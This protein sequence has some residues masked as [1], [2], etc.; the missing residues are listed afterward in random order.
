VMM[1]C[2]G[3]NDSRC[4][5]VDE[6]SGLLASTILQMQ[7]KSYH[8]ADTR[9]RPG[10]AATRHKNMLYPSTASL[11]RVLETN[12]ALRSSEAARGPYSLPV[13]EEEIWERHHGNCQES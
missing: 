7:Y 10:P 3:I 8:G 9:R 4:T 2:R 5:I 1:A 13:L 11:H 12:K 6:H